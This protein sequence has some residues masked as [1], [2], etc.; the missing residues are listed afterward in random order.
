M[1]FDLRT[2]AFMFGLLSSLMG[3]MLLLIGWQF[4]SI[5]GVREY[6]LGDLCLGLV[7]VLGTYYLTPMAPADGRLVVE[8]VCLILGQSLCLNGIRL[9]TGKPPMLVLPALIAIAGGINTYWWVVVD[10]DI[11]MRMVINSFIFCLVFLLCIRALWARTESRLRLAYRLT[12]GSYAIL[13]LTMLLRLVVALRT[14]GPVE[15]IFISNA[16]TP[17]LM[18][19]AQFCAAFGFMLMLNYRL[20]ADLEQ[21]ASSDS[22]TGA[23]NRRSF[24]AIADRL[25]GQ[26]I[27][28]QQP[29]A[30]IMLDVDHFKSINDR[31]GHP[32]GDLVLQSVAELARASIRDIDHLGRYG[33][34][35]FCV[36]LPNATENDAFQIA[37]RMRTG[38][39]C[40][41]LP[42]D[43]NDFV[44]CTISL[45]VC[46]SRDLGF[47]YGAMLKQ[48]DK[49]LYYAKQSGR[50]KTVTVTELKEVGGNQR[51]DLRMHTG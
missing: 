10:T 45:G 20:A 22:L 27:K 14:P 36:L 1:Y 21:A 16:P 32:Q 24:D 38:I 46:D 41:P 18:T 39:A 34:E 6:A 31:Y 11:R 40:T 37:E 47:D 9:F 43:E 42:I 29:L 17:M 48:A 3:G 49:A 13:A 19:V 44:T 50:N 7:F 28:R 2:A 23:L 25:C 5:R 8:V 30:L 35:E 51:S 15:N 4:K 33:G 26:L 12:A